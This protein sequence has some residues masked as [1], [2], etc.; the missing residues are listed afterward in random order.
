MTLVN[1]MLESVE[2]KSEKLTQEEVDA[3]W[4]DEIANRIGEFKNGEVDSIPSSELWVA[5][6]NVNGRHVSQRTRHFGAGLRKW[7]FPVANNKEVI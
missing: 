1:T 2:H 6:E 7:I 3:S 5:R 4:N